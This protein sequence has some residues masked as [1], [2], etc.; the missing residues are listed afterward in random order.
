MGIL[1]GTMAEKRHKTISYRRAVWMEEDARKS[2][3]EYFLVS[4][5]Q[6]L[7][8]VKK[9][10]FKRPDGQFVKCIRFRPGENGGS[11]FHLVAET[12]GDTAS[13]ISSA[14]EDKE[15]SDVGTASPP[16]GA[17]FMDGDLFVYVKGNHVSLCATS[18][19]DASF[20]V[21]CDEVFRKAKLPAVS[22]K[23]DFQK[24][25]NV[26][27]MKLIEAEGV[28]E[29]DMNATLYVATTKYAKRKKDAVGAVGV[30]AK[31]LKALF[32]PDEDMESDSIQVSLTLR[33]DDRMVSGKV[34]GNKRLKEIAQD[35][36]DDDDDYVI[37][38]RKGQRISQNEIYVR[39]K[40]DLDRHGKSVKRD[41][42][43]QALLDFH[44]QLV[45]S[46]IVVQ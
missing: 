11:L 45:A 22:T 28:K 36:V 5:H 21:Y 44:K 10:K 35:V 39:S 17:E 40:V 8:T 13:T 9:R 38:T 19:R 34:L 32:W 12:P 16:K 15:A 14:D 7:K 4:P 41:A 31:H 26:E 33:T 6:K 20:K 23:F 18:L 24:V 27:K 25:A 43:W 42:A 46:G 37:V 2:T 3:L 30:A 1:E 29:I